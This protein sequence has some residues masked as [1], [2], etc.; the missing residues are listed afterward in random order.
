M[1]EKLICEGRTV[2]IRVVNN[3]LYTQIKGIYKLNLTEESVFK[4]Y[5]RVKNDMMYAEIAHHDS[6]KNFY[7]LLKRYAGNKDYLTASEFATLINKIGYNGF[8]YNY[9][10]ISALEEVKPC[11]K[12]L[13]VKDSTNTVS[14]IRYDGKTKFYLENFVIEHKDCNNKNNVYCYC[15]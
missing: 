2:G 12:S 5:M 11:K 8:Y 4:A 7:K 13:R 10:L 9:G 14:Y 3:G 6:T 1:L 15:N